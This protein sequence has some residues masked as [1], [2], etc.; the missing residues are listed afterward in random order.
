M[1]KTNLSAKNDFSWNAD[2]FH[3][4]N[5]N[6]LQKML[7]SHRFNVKTNF[8][9]RILNFQCENRLSLYKNAL[10]NTTTH[11]QTEILVHK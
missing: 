2:N 1:Q 11:F 3:I 4:R 5:L 7:Y 8:L 9:L 6:I 10:F